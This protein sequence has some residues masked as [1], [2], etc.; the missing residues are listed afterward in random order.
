MNPNDLNK[1]PGDGG[2]R[3]DALHYKGQRLG[4]KETVVNDDYKIPFFNDPLLYN[5][6]VRSNSVQL[7]EHELVQK[8]PTNLDAASA[9][10]EG[11]TTNDFWKLSD[12]T[13][14]G[15]SVKSL[16]KGTCAQ[17]AASCFESCFP[18]NKVTLIQLIILNLYSCFTIAMLDLPYIDAAKK[19][20]GSNDILYVISLI[21][22]FN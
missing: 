1:T 16:C 12:E 3:A 9:A 2:G 11:K 18:K 15:I 4:S 21:S 19:M 20:S 22:F 8:S 17:W 7:N 10:S 5:T 6:I 13:G 14:A